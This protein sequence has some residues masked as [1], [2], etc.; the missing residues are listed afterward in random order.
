M[1]GV[2][3]VIIDGELALGDKR[4]E[5]NKWLFSFDAQFPLFMTAQPHAAL[6]IFVF[7]FICLVK[8][9]CTRMISLICWLPRPVVDYT[10]AALTGEINSACAQLNITVSARHTG[11]FH[12]PVPFCGR[13]GH[14][15]SQDE[16]ENGERMPIYQ[17]AIARNCVSQRSHSRS[18]QLASAQ[19][20]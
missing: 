4:A 1:G 19:A 15:S 18:R 20:P 3:H 2:D 7:N 9:A 12:T 8:H 5:R 13:S 16:L 6:P 11:W 17:S 10:I 14:M